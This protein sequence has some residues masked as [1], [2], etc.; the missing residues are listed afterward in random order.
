MEYKKLYT[1]EEIREVETW[2]R[3][4]AGSLPASL[5]MGR[6]MRIPDLRQTLD[7]YIENAKLHRENPTF[8]AQTFLLF[9][10]RQKLE[11]AGL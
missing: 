2:F 7:T 5:E 8:S 6:E 11:E 10:I 3:E 1:E 9:R 4:R